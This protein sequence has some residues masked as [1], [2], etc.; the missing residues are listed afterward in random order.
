MPRM[1]GI[2]ATYKIRECGYTLPIIAWTCHDR[3]Y[4]EG[5]CQLAGM[6]EF[7]EK[8][9][10]TLVQDVIEALIACQVLEA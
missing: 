4:K 3:W 1:D 7:I 5:A 2:T 6:N 10:T 8:D 9:C